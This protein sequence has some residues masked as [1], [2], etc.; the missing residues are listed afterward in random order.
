MKL[1]SKLSE[2]PGNGPILVTLGNFDGLHLGHRKLLEEAF[3]ASK[4][5]NGYLAVITFC[6]HPQEIFLNLDN[7]YINSFQERRELL[8]G[9][10]VDFLCEIGFDEEFSSLSPDQFLNDY[11]LNDS[12]VKTLFLGHD[13]S[14]GKSKSGTFEFVRDFLSKTKVNLKVFPEYLKDGEKVSSRVIRDFIRNG[15]ILKANEFLGR[16]FF[17]SGKVVKGMGRGATIEI[18]TVNIEVD[19]KRLIPQRGVYF[20]KTKFKNNTF[21]SIT[22]VGFNPTISEDKKIKIETHILD[23]RDQIYGEE[24]VIYFLKNWRDEKKFSNLNELKAQINLDI[25]ARTDFS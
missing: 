10:G 7:F 9:V 4:K 23:F 25:K 22:N 12:R 15:E 18:P 3:N 24:I 1:V 8:E 2:I 6:P 19:A 13:F 11:I 21:K 16:E 14:F 17:I 20:T 5:I